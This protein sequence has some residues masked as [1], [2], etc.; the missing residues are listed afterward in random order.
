VGTSDRG[1][2]QQDKPLSFGGRLVVLKEE[3][4]EYAAL[5]YWIA[6]LVAMTAKVLA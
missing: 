2:W 3:L 6:L 5:P 1:N 4:E